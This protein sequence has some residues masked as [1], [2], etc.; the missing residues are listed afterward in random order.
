MEKKKV[1]VSLVL[2]IVALIVIAVLAYF[3]YEAYNKIADDKDKNETNSISTDVQNEAAPESAN[4]TVNTKID[5]IPQYVTLMDKLNKDEVLYVTEAIENDDTY[6]INGIVYTKFVMTKTELDEIVNKGT[7]IYKDEELKVVKKDDKSKIDYEFYGKWQDEERL[8]YIAREK[9]K[10]FYYIEN[11]TENSTEWRMTN[12]HKTI[13]LS[14]KIKVETDD[15]TVTIDKKFKNFQKVSSEET[16]P[17]TP[18][19]TF[20]FKD[21]KC[22]KVVEHILGY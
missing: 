16:Y 21:G 6:T 13:T 12:E 10:G 14:K 11:T 15:G 1:S 17:P 5:V 9:E 22:T 2:L 18:A 19:Y 4:T 3:L 7:Y 20:S 8:N